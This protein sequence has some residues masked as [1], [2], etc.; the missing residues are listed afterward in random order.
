MGKTFTVLHIAEFAA[1]YQGNFIPS[2]IKLKFELE[3]TG[4]RI[5]LALPQRVRQH[6]WFE[7][8][9]REFGDQLILIPPGSRLV[10]LKFFLNIIKSRRV[11]IVHTHFKYFDMV[12]YF[13]ALLGGAKVVWH[14]HSEWSISLNLLRISK[15]FIKYRLLGLKA[16]N[17]AVSD[18]ISDMLAERQAH[19]SRTIIAYNGIALDRITNAV[20]DREKTRKT[21]TADET[22]FVFTILAWSPDRKGLDIALDA[23]QKLSKTESKKFLLVVVGGDETRQFL[24][25]HSRDNDLNE[26]VKVIAPLQNIFELLAAT[27]CFCSFARYEGFPYALCESMAFG[28]VVLANDIPALKPLHESDAVFFA[29]NDSSDAAEKMKMIMNMPDGQKLKISQ[30]NSRF[31]K[32]KYS[33]ETWAKQIVEIYRTRL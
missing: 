1:P 6:E 15:D 18:R 7:E 8:C 4:G 5:L 31:I 28:N 24:E 11:H 13:A 16:L 14:C 30:S 27:D 9:K 32:D 22:T 23:A 26:I 3:K 20:T 21:L 33:A 2:L 12:G 25:A 29:Q 17:I 19:K 10:Q